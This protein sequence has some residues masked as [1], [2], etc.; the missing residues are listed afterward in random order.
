MTARAALVAGGFVLEELSSKKIKNKMATVAR[1]LSDENEKSE[2]NDNGEEK[3]DRNDPRVLKAVAAREENPGI[4]A[5]DALV[6]GGFVLE[7]L[8]NR[9]IQNRLTAVSRSLARR[10]KASK[11]SS[12]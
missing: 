9:R 4:G 2:G 7:G 10:L 6:V 3:I 12:V 1:R 5:R 11:Q 8:S